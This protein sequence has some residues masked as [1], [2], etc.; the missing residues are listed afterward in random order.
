MLPVP[1]RRDRFTTEVGPDDSGSKPGIEGCNHLPEI[2]GI[3]APLPLPLLADPTVGAA[4]C[5]K[6]GVAVA[7]ASVTTKRKSRWTFMTTSDALHACLVGRSEAN[8]M[9]K[10]ENS[11]SYLM[12]RF[13]HGRGEKGT[14]FSIPG[15]LDNGHEPQ[16]QGVWPCWYPHRFS[17]ALTR[18][19]NNC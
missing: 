19:L 9:P 3:D 14:L 11:A 17:S 7:A 5:P 6:T 18:R 8:C 10:G 16:E 15:D 12:R 2:S 13:A 1:L 4:D